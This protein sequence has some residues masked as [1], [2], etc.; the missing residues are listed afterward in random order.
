MMFPLKRWP[1]LVLAAVHTRNPLAHRVVAAWPRLHL[2][3]PI[4]VVGVP[5]SG[6]SIFV[7]HF[8]THRDL[9][10]WSEAP[11]MWDARYRARDTDHRWTAE[12]ATESAIRRI[13]NNFAYY[14]KW[15]GKSRFVNKH[16][17]NSL[18]IP[19]LMA[20]WPDAHIICIQ[21]DPRAV[22]WSLVCR[23]RREH[24]RSKYPLGQF[25]R[26]P[27]WREI[28]AIPDIIERFAGAVVAT[29]ATL[30]DDLGRCVPAGQRHTVRYEDL[31]ADCGATLARVW[32]SCGLSRDE[33]ALGDVPEGLTNMNGKWRRDMKPG[34]IST[35][36]PIVEP[37]LSDLGYA[38]N[39][40]FRGSA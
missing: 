11:T 21:R 8:A 27:G 15:K 31:A 22:V 35:M 19:F 2:D 13:E 3:R 20:G 14:T 23:T 38:R 9:A 17:R 10:H 1:R 39:V 16:P 33:E 28:D 36:L 29:H 26:P 37:M 24:W 32:K 40:S 4:F 7:R 34:D 18:R 30:G 5:R 6:T 12:Q 25:A